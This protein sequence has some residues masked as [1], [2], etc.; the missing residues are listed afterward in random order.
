MVGELVGNVGIEGVDCGHVDEPGARVAPNG[1][2]Q[3]PPAQERRQLVDQR[4]KRHDGV[5]E[6][7]DRPRELLVE[8]FLGEVPEL[9][10]RAYERDSRDQLS[11]ETRLYFRGVDDP[12]RNETAPEL[13]GHET[14]V[15]IRPAR[16]AIRSSP[17]FA[18]ARW[19]AKA[20]PEPRQG[21]G[22]SS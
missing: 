19:A 3:K 5:E 4:R 10:H 12:R 1:H 22:Q 2:G 14:Y 21:T 11:I 20:S 9:Q 15:I 16:L 7:D 6:R 13:D 8:R 17:N 18:R